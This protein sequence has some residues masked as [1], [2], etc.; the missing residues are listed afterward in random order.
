MKINSNVTKICLGVCATCAV[1]FGGD[2]GMGVA[3]A[4]VI[5]IISIE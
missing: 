2:F 3:G 1:I 4:L 5:A